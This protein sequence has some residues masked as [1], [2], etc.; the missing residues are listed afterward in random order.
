MSVKQQ[1]T[2]LGLTVSRESGI[3][4][5]RNSGQAVKHKGDIL[6]HTGKLVQSLLL[7]VYSLGAVADFFS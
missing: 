1:A 7:L 5:I 4:T 6:H 3:N 2:S